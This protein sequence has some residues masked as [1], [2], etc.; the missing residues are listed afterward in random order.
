M[1]KLKKYLLIYLDIYLF[2]ALI[3]LAFVFAVKINYTELERYVISNNSHFYSTT[4]IFINNL[5]VYTFIIL[6][7][8]S[9]GISSCIILFINFL[10]IFIYFFTESLHSSFYHSISYI[11][12]YGILEL[13]GF[14]MAFS[15]NILFLKSLYK[16][17]FSKLK[18]EGMFRL[19]LGIIL[20][21]IAAFIEINSL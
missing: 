11:L 14:F 21:F 2:L 10:N 9:L 17:D 19:I 3:F 5:K 7:I 4:D 6:G 16:K 13:S 15:I 18:N 1:S 8:F 12:R 20:L